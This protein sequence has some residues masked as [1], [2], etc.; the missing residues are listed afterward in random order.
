MSHSL[1]VLSKDSIPEH[2][3]SSTPYLQHQILTSETKIQ[4]SKLS[5]RLSI[6]RGLNDAA[7]ERFFVTLG[8]A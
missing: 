4:I 7:T 2:Q 5:A 6:P 3:N 1:K 8:N